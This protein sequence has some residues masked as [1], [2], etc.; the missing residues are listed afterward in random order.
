MA[1][2]ERILLRNPDRTKKGSRIA[3]DQYDIARRAALAALPARGPGITLTA[4]R[5]RVATRLAR[6]KGWD[7]DASASW[8]SMAI[9][10]DLEARGE[11]RRIGRSPQRL[12][13][14]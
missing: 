5:D 14:G 13:R 3:R 2:A 1:A 4:F 10:L 9:K 11:I 12:I 8:Y 7:K 6:A